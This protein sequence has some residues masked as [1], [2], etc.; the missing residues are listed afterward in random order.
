MYIK[1]TVFTKNRIF[2]EK[3]KCYYFDPEAARRE[4][5][6]KRYPTGEGKHERNRRRAYQNK[7]YLIYN[8][9]SEGDMWVTLTYNKESIPES[10]EAAHR[11][12]MRIMNLI[13]KKLK[14]GGIPFVYFLKTEAGNGMR[15]HH[16]LLIRNNFD[17][18]DMIYGY[19]KKF[20]KV[21]D[22]QEIYDM[23]NGK[24]VTY[25]LD[26]GD[27][28]G[29]SFEKYAHSRNLVRPKIK[30]QIMPMKS[31]RMIP[32]P[33]KADDG[34]EYVIQNLYNGYTDR[35]GYVY[36]SYEFVRRDRE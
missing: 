25:F 10:P 5:R 4:R 32:L 15:V 2:V 33:P 34:A 27:H 12:L 35:D 21:R 8:N 31:F 28:K 20:G 29:L 11:E 26:G 1:R 24:L 14:K 6:A 16:H 3:V 7:K 22:F 36:Q 18:I 19:W 17:M 13:Q 23:N 30:T 9:F